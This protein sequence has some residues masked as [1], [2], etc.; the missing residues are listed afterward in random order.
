MKVIFTV[1]RLSGLS[2]QLLSCFTTAKITFTSILS[3][4]FVCLVGWLLFFLSG[5]GE[6]TNKRSDHM[7]N[8]T[9]ILPTTFPDATCS[10]PPYPSVNK[11][12]ELSEEEKRGEFVSMSACVMNVNR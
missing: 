10:L 3:V 7:E 1:V 9:T 5:K 8:I 2:L 6:H 11:P 12:S 4:L